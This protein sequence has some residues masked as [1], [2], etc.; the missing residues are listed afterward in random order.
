[1]S[2][3]RDFVGNEMILRGKIICIDSNST[4]SDQRC[5]VNVVMGNTS[6]RICH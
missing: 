3:G 2:P 4:K 1:M 6:S 5:S